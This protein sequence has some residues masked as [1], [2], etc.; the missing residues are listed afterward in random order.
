M[1]RQVD[2]LLTAVRIGNRSSAVLETRIARLK[3]RL[4][5]R[6]VRVVELERQV[7]TLER[8]LHAPRPHAARVRGRRRARARDVG[9]GWF[10]CD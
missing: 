6:D 4:R 9:C 8:L 2:L 1:Q 10:G 5:E 7:A 3:A